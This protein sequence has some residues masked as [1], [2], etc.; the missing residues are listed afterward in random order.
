M[1]EILNE[2][3]IK[4]FVAQNCA[5]LPENLFEPI[6]FGSEKTLLQVL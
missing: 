1:M 3:K 6:L 2:R 4:R 5:A